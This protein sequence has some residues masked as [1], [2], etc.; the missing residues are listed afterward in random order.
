ML[1]YSG[2]C[3]DPAGNVW[4]TFFTMIGKYMYG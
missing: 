4:R 2:Y 3:P 1:I